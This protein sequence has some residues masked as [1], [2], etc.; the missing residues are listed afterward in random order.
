LINNYPKILLIIFLIF[1]SSLQAQRRDLVSPEPDNIDVK[2]FRAINNSQSG[3]LNTV[4]P[5]TDKSI[6]FTSTLVPATLFAVSRAKNNYYDENSSVLLILTEG[7]SAGITFGIKNIFR[8]E[9]PFAILSNVHYN[10][11]K[12]LLDRYSFPSGHSAMT[13]SMATSLTLRYPDKPVLISGLFL[14]STVVSLGRIYLGVHY[15]SD[16]L[17]GMLIGSGSA[18]II[19]SLRKEIIKGKNNLFNE[20]GRVDAN[21]KTV[22]GTLILTSFIA[23]DVLNFILGGIRSKFIEKSKL[24]VD[25]R[26]YENRI[27][28]SYGF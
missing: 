22:S 17:A 11:S 26:G 19:Y 9:R 3:F 2:I 28:V 8:R 7:L 5:V 1:A 12:F 6:L 15:P 24:G 18:A 20:S 13:F 23:S 10:K 25:L 27:N 21:Q 4:V 16:V 14:Y